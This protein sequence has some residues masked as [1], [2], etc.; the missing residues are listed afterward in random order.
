MVH[1]IAI[2]MPT[3]PTRRDRTIAPVTLA[4]MGMAITAQVRIYFIYRRVSLLIEL[5]HKCYL[6]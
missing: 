1:I 4:M 2:L 6:A 5:V 3:A